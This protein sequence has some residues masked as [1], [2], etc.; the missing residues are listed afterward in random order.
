[1]S[2]KTISVQQLQRSFG[3]DRHTHSHTKRKKDKDPVTFIKAYLPKAR[4]MAEACRDFVIF[5]ENTD[6]RYKLTL[7]PTKNSLLVHSI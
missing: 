7:K 1:M 2:K 6:T 4:N 3:T 5:L